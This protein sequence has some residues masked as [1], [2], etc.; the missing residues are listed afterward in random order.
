M[1]ILS[2]PIIKDFKKGILVT[3]EFDGRI[4][5]GYDGEPIAAAMKANGIQVHRYTTKLQQPRGIFCA[6]GRCTDCVMV[7]DG[8]ANVRTCVTPAASRHEGGNTAWD[9]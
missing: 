8:T 7:V 3:F 4:M 6:I 1:R 2:H 9:R 5:H